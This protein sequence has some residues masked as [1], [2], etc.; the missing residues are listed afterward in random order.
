MHH[1]RAGEVQVVPGLYI[2][3]SVNEIQRQ[4]SPLAFLLTAQLTSAS[5]PLPSQAQWDTGGYTQPVMMM[6]YLGEY[7]VSNA[8]YEAVLCSITHMK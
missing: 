4:K 7:L 1:T 6:E 3:R 5:Q 8:S 2:Q